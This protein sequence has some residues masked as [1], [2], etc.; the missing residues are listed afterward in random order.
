MCCLVTPRAARQWNIFPSVEFPC[1]DGIIEMSREALCLGSLAHSHAVRRTHMCITTHTHT[2][3]QSNH[4][5]RT[6]GPSKPQS[7][8]LLCE[9]T[10]GQAQTNT[11][12]H[13]GPVA[14]L[15]KRK[16]NYNLN[17]YS[18]KL[19]YFST[20]DIFTANY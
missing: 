17:V 16:V 4:L 19:L 9:C 14:C 11:F 15:F 2:N 12:A 10:Q 18:L 7:L 1:H 20:F 3:T 5:E 6:G 13:S 8:V